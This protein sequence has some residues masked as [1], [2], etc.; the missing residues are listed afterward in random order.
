MTESEI[1]THDQVPINNKQQAWRDL[2][3]HGIDVVVNVSIVTL[4][5]VTAYVLVRILH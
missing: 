3:D 4:L 5:S 1:D 2:R